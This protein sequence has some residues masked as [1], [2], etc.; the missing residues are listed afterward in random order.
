[1]FQQ[2][3]SGNPSGRPKGAVNKTT[4]ELREMIT[5][6]LLENFEE[7]QRSF[8]DLEPKQKVKVY[9]DMLRFVLPRHKVVDEVGLERLSNEELDEM[10]ERLKEAASR[11]F[12]DGAG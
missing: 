10:L 4:K 6:F 12:Q 9:C 2:G 5:N 1:M 11:E 7:V 8:K 3:Q